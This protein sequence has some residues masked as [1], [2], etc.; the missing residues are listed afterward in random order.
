MKFPASL[1]SYCFSLH[2]PVS[3]Q[4]RSMW[5]A[6]FFSFLFKIFMREKKNNPKNLTGCFGLN[7]ILE[8]GPTPLVVRVPGGGAGLKS[9]ALAS[10]TPISLPIPRHLNI[11]SSTKREFAAPQSS[12]ENSFALTYNQVVPLILSREKIRSC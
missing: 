4:N 8:V 2:L 9:M 10:L 12:K 7:V 5:T 6:Y 1:S 3:V 11:R